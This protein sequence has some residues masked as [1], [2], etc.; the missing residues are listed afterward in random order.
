MVISGRGNTWLAR[1]NCKN[2][3]VRNQATH[4]PT[5]N[6]LSGH[7]GTQSIYY[8][9]RFFLQYLCGISFFRLRKQVP[10]ST[11]HSTVYSQDTKPIGTQAA[12]I[13][14]R[15][16]TR[17]HYKSPTNTATRPNKVNDSHEDTQ[18]HTKQQN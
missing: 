8:F 5:P 18:N 6:K 3:M 4:R 14:T 1:D 7:H 11:V 2:K 13:Q 17:D 16:D 15:P 9:C 12:R 10:T